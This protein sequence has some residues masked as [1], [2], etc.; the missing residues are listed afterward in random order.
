GGKEPSAQYR[1]MSSSFDSEISQ[2]KRLSEEFVVI[3][4]VKDMK[5]LWKVEKLH[6]FNGHHQGIYGLAFE[7]ESGCLF[8][9]GA[10][11]FVVR[12]KPGVSDQGELIARIPEPVFVLLSLRKDILLAGTAHG[13]IY[14][15][16]FGKN[17]GVRIL[18]AHSGGVFALVKTASGEGWYSG[19]KDG[20]LLE[21]NNLGSWTLGKKCSEESLRCISVAGDKIAAGF[22]DYHIREWKPF[23]GGEPVHDIIAHHNSVFSIAYSKDGRWL[24]SGGRD[25]ALKQWDVQ[26]G[27]QLLR[28]VPAHWSHI[29]HLDVSPNGNMIATASMDKTIRIW[30]AETLE[31]LKVIDATKTEA[32]NSSVNRV[33]WLDHERIASCADD[34]TIRVFRIFPAD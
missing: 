13:F 33:V 21:W 26:N 31:L 12:W 5:R 9:S 16:Q 25:A 30:E 22:S 19:G 28:E 3:S 20:Y 32:H 2:R 29:N 1:F 7:A 4:D 11:G 15:I 17:P 34:R 8:S 23:N 10:D 27:L 14:V 24:F 18:N 6:Q